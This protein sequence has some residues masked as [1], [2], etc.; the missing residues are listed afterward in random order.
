[1]GIP[2]DGARSRSTRSIFVSTTTTVSRRTRTLHVSVRAG[3]ANTT[4]DVFSYIF[5][6]SIRLRHLPC[7]TVHTSH[8]TT[9]VRARLWLL[10]APDYSPVR[11]APKLT[12]PICYLL[13]LQTNRCRSKNPCRSVTSRQTWTRRNSIRL[14]AQVG[15]QRRRALVRT[16]PVAARGILLLLRATWTFERVPVCSEKFS[17]FPPHPPTPPFKRLYR[18]IF[19]TPNGTETKSLTNNN[20]NPCISL[21]PRYHLKIFK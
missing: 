20:E 14:R 9:A 6:C 21:V 7:S 12:R 15:R 18:V 4:N 17:T 11:F 2:I 10:C 1:M 8:A 19:K 3:R 13:T 5:T 16:H